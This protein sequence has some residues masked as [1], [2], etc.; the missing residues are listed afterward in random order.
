MPLPQQIS[1]IYFIAFSI[2]VF[3]SVYILMLNGRSMLNRIFFA[4]CLSISIWAFSFSIANSAPDYETA[5]L[6]RRIAAFGWGT[7]YSF[8]LHFILIL[9]QKNRLL[10][11]KWIYIFLYL[12]AIINIFVFN[13]IKEVAIGQYHLIHS[14]AGW[15]NIPVNNYLDWYFNFYYMGFTIAGII[16]L[17]HCRLQS[18]DLKMKKQTSILIVCFI[19][20]LTIGT[21]TDM[22]ANIYL[23]DAVP[24]MA[25]ALQIIPI[26]GIFYAIRKYRLMLPEMKAAVAEDGKILDE[27]TRGKLYLNLT[28]SFVF[29][30]M[31]NFAIQFFLLNEPMKP[32][33]LFSSYLLGVGILI[34]LILQLKIKEKFIDYIVIFCMMVIM[35]MI[36][37]KFIDSASTTVWSVSFIFI[38]LLVITSKKGML[39]WPST[40]ILI[41]QIVVWILAPTRTIVISSADHLTRIGILLI[42]L[43]LAYFVNQIYIKRLTETETQVKFQK[44]ISYVSSGFVNASASNLNKKIDEMLE[45][46]GECSQVDC[47]TLS[48]IAKNKEE[49]MQKNQWNHSEIMDLDIHENS[50]NILEQFI[51][52]QILNNEI[53]HIPNISE[54]FINDKVEGKGLMVWH[55]KS[56]IA[57]PVAS[58]DRILGFLSLNTRKSLKVWNEDQKKM[59]QIIANLFADVLMK[60]EA[61]KEINYMAYYDSLTNLP[62]RVL[63]RNR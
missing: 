63:L 42:T 16:I 4:S 30:S 55:I 10:K 20:S 21:L 60:V 41:L 36:T 31:I 44:M 47:V 12:P 6:W 5:L 17:I 8:L 7:V 59:L 33:L 2:Y 15:T 25:P 52:T 46:I 24:Q 23:V 49:I 43:W 14:T 9:T 53:V 28:I 45:C 1:M 56:M 3:F 61:E 32:S 27:I 11:R 18:K 39:I 57:I 13:I 29:G 50:A 51:V 48:V 40:F 22:I 62:N 38:F 35:T 19:C 58:K 54:K 34:Q 37:F 26:T